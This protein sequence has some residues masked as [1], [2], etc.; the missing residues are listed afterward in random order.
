[1]SKYELRNWFLDIITLT[2][3]IVLK[4]NQLSFVF[5]N[6]KGEL[7]KKISIEKNQNNHLE[8]RM[9]K[10]VLLTVICLIVGVTFSVYAEAM[11]VPISK[12]G[13]YASIP[14][15]K[16]VSNPVITSTK[17]TLLS[18][19]FTDTTFP[20]TGW[21]RIQTNT[22]T[23][24]GYSCFWDRFTTPIDFV[25]TPPACAG[26]WWSYNHQDEWLITPSITLTGS[27]GGIY[28]LKWWYY[29]YRGSTYGDHY[30]TKISTDG[31]T[32]W[33]ILYDLSTLTTPPDTGWNYYVTPVQIDLSVYADS[34][35]KIAFHAKD[36]PT[37]DG[38]WY[39]WGIDDIEVGYPTAIEEENPNKLPTITAL[40]A[41]KPN[42]VANGLAHISF[43]ISEPTKA[44][45][46]IYDASGR[47][48]KTLVNSNLEHGVYNLNWNGT[49]D[50]NNKVAE[51]IYFYTLQTEN[52]NF[53]KKLVFTR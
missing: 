51:G 24:G 16:P 10:K 42:P 30:Y 38:L 22:G 25:H 23:Q 15:R 33:T 4:Q 40:N 43:T 44:S 53:T 48:V 14:M 3:N 37:N 11:M 35:I 13:E 45:L 7:I 28:Y 29:G 41:P 47:I 46:K 12:T 49:D 8:E 5:S 32:N 2:K 50:Q 1:M 19:S 20:P 17:T 27:S 26:L 39:A 52:N 36:P 18:E 21:T 6:K 9:Y 31:G 34:T